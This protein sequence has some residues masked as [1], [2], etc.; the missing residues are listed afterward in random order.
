M[1]KKA[2]HG[3]I[4]PALGLLAVSVAGSVIAWAQQ[5]DDL[6][7]PTINPITQGT[8]ETD[9]NLDGIEDSEQTEEELRRQRE[10]V[11]P[12][13]LVPPDDGDGDQNRADNTRADRNGNNDDRNGNDDNQ[14]RSDNQNADDDGAIVPQQEPVGARRN[15]AEQPAEQVGLVDEDGNVTPLANV[16]VQRIQSGVGAVPRD[17]DP[18]APLG[19]RV[20]TFSVFPTVTE[21]IGYTSNADFFE[22]GEESFFS[23]TEARVTFNS[24]WSVHDLRGEVGGSFQEFFNGNSE[25][26]PTFDGNVQLRLDVDSSTTATVGTDVSLTTENAVSDNLSLSGVAFVDDR[27]VV[28]RTG[29]FVE[30]ERTGGRYTGSLRGSF[31]NETFGD[32]DLS[33]GTT[34]DQGDRNNTLFQLRGRLNYEASPIVQPFVQATVGRTIFNDSVD[35]N[36]NERD[37]TTLALRT[38]IAFNQGEKL[39]GDIAVGY[40]IERF[41]DSALRDLDGFTIDGTINWSPQDLTTVTATAS[42]SFAGSTSL[43]EAGSITYSGTL[44][45]TRDVRA[46]LSLNA[47]VLASFTDNEDSGRQDT[48]YQFETGAE[49]RLNRSWAFIGRLGYETSDSTEEGSSFDAYTARLGLRWQR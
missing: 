13:P 29:G 28:Y 37:S 32:A 4:I 26:L 7:R 48:N 42:T 25:S 35:R 24:N 18:F 43:N 2:R 12:D 1:S 3:L 27:P 36:G 14:S 47:R 17:D 38:G 30:V 44:G 39:N 15:T 16:R 10:P 20:G 33:D 6:L 49:W 34:L 31:D 46:N 21:T 5:A 19:L 8:P 41:E 45:V 9:S 40:S 23:Q 11:F 22:N